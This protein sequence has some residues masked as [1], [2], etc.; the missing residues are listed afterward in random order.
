MNRCALL[1]LAALTAAG[2]ATAGS[3]RLLPAEVPLA[4]PDARQQLLAIEE[5]DGVATADRTSGARFESSDP[6]V[7]VVGTDGVVR[8]AADGEAVVTATSGGRRATARVRVT[9]FREAAARHDTFRNHVQPVLTR[10]GCNSGACHGALAGK[11]GLK[12]SLRG[13]DPVADHFALTRQ[14]QARRVDREEPARSLLLL[15]ATR[16]VPHGGGERFAD[17]SPEYEVVR[18]WVAAGAAAPADADPRL[19]RLEVFPAA[20]RL[21]PTDTLRVVVRAWYADGHAEDVTT[22]A[23]FGSSEEQVA[24]ASEDGLVKV[25]GHGEAA[26]TVVFGDRVAAM[27]VA[28]PFPNALAPEAFADS[29]RLNFIDGH[30]LKK[31]QSLRLPP[32]PQCTDREFIRRAFLDAAGILPSPT[33][34]ER[35]V[36]D[37]AADKRAKLIDALLARPEFTDYWAYKWS[38]VL[39]V[40]TRKLPGPAMWAFYR[41]VRQSV[42]DNKP[43]DRF[44]RDVLTARGGNLQNGGANY[45]V[46]HKD[47]SDL[48]E[49]TAVTFLGTSITCARCHN[50]PLEK[51]TQDQYWAF[52]NLFGRVGMKNGEQAGEVVVT[53]LPAGEV[54]HPR[55]GVA[56]APAPLDGKPLPSDSPLDRRQYLAD[57]LTA[58]DNPFFARALV[59][60]VWKNFLGRGLV[61][62]EDDLRATNPP[63]N[64]ELLDALAADFIAH[65]F[66]VRHTIRMVMNSA[67]YQR[68]AKPL[69]QNA[70]D[71]RFYSRYLIRRLPAEVILDAYS[72]V[73]AVPTP[74]TQVYTG[75]EGGTAATTNYPPGTRALQ[76]PDSRV[77]SRFLDSF[78]RPDRVVTC[79]C[80]RQQDASVGQALHLNNGQTLNDKLRAKDGRVEKWL[81]EKVGDEEAVRRA[82]ALALGREPAA[83][84]LAKCKSALSGTEGTRREALEDLLWALL[85]S[86]EFLFNH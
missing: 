84:E 51:W 54:P 7:A 69:P 31:L 18:A 48:T 15:K 65:K 25:A 42:A 66:D 45:F 70:A 13:Y 72:Q 62:A 64:P 76:L 5:A 82:F 6:K 71:D 34:V 28:S 3:L 4:G 36:A 77:A 30:V 85:T 73:T 58:P 10:A 8:A 53:S 9:R 35:F 19:D 50:H 86:K 52:A 78:G 33:E 68:S 60:R 16:T 43:W 55:R 44:A 49:T 81:A 1:A 46:L 26:I 37:P 83:G 39:L 57:W 38:D 22:L 79:A 32:S 21:K 67:A 74:F 47:T 12:L 27:T 40:S 24:T 20:A 56:V 75:V 11:G 29:P 41:D 80:E 59:N 61:E 2:P 63:T 17:D 14:A 23:R